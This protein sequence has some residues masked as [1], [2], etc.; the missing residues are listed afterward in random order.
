MPKPST[1][2]RG[3]GYLHQQLREKLRPMV[4]VGLVCCARC[5]ALI[6][7]GER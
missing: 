7:S 2:L 5:G 4:E 6:E 1:T 3:Y